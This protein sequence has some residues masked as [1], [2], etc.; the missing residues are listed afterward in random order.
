[1]AFVALSAV[2]ICTPGPDTALT[3]HNTLVGGR[4]GGVW[5]AAGVA[6][7]QLVW[8]IAAGL[9]AASLLRT[10]QPAFHMLKTLGEVYLCYLGV[11]SLRAA[12]STAGRPADTAKRPTQLG[13]WRPY[14][15]GL[16]NDLANPKMATF[17]V[18]LLPPVHP[19]TRRP[20][21]GAGRIPAARCAV[22]RPDIRLAVHLRGGRSKKRCHVT[23]GHSRLRNR[24]GAAT[25]AGRG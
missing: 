3:V 15:Q 2:V 21:H 4:T 24:G 19:R 5:T 7:G 13:R 22:L 25:S 1:M 8:T 11:Q 17:F 10:S 23:V 9:G 16:I 18:S 14:R 12:W 20:R 6:S